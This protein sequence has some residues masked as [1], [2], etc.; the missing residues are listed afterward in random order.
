MKKIILL[1]FIY[2]S[3][4]LFA[5]TTVIKDSFDFEI[6]KVKADLNK[7]GIIDFVVVT[8]DTLN[9]ESPYRLQIYFGQAKGDPQ[10]I[11]STTKAIDPQ[12]P[13][14]KEAGTNGNGFSDIT[15]NKGVVSINIE[16]LRGHYEHKFR[17]QHNNFELIGCSSVYADGR[18]TITESDFNLS[19]GV[20]IVIT[21]RADSDKILSNKKKK[22]LIRPLPKLQDFTPFENELY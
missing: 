11:V 21:E 18:G 20:Q 6:T 9:N 12:F 7:D 10:L 13:S 16:L 2:A 5:Q 17:F 22:I 15:I 19:T 14:G 3:G 8:Q 1:L 4:N